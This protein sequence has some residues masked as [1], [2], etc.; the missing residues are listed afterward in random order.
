MTET[1]GFA[2]DPHIGVFSRVFEDIA[3]VAPS[4]PDEYVQVLTDRLDVEVVLTTVQGSTIVGSLLAGNSRGMIASA[5]ATAEE[6]AVL[7]EYRDVMLLERGMNA[8][9]N[10]ILAND[11]L[12]VVHPEMPE[13]TAEAI[14]TFLDVPVLMMTLGGVPTVG[15]AGVATSRGLL[16][17]PRATRQEID[18]LEAATDLPVGTGSI[19]MGST[20]VGTGLVANSKG[21]LA[22]LY[23]SGFELGRIE[24]VFGF[25]E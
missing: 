22:G 25:L 4:A 7:S 17:H 6:I 12:A 2:G 18:R 19:N 10:V 1:I 8:A 20:L 9:G 11:S 3:I 24:E 16:I 21:Y 5:L 15:M 13:K 14:G 23:T